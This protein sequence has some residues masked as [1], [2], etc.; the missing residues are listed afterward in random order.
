[1]IVMTPGCRYSPYPT[2][3]QC[4]VLNVIIAIFPS[5]KLISDLIIRAVA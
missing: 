4:K 2:E 1:M 5:S 3:Y